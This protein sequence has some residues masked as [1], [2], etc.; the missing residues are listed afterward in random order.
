MAKKVT[1]V[2]KKKK[3]EKIPPQEF[4]VSDKSVKKHEIDARCTKCQDMSIPKETT[5]YAYTTI[6]AK[7]DSS[8]RFRIGGTCSEKGCGTKISKF[9]GKELAIDLIKEAKK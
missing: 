2:P 8:Y 3:D 7:G 9:I 4:D 5:L 6:T 1:S